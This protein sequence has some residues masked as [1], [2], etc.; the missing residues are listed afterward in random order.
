MDARPM[1]G[2]R[3][4]FWRRADRGLRGGVSKMGDDV[5]RIM[6]V[7]H[8]AFDPEYG[9]AWNRRQ[10]E[11]ALLLGN[12][13]YLLADAGGEEP[14]GEVPASEIAGFT[15]SRHGFGEEE[16]LLFAV[17]PRFRRRGV[18][19]RLLERFSLAAQAR[20]ARRLLL[21]M[22]RGNEA[23]S[24]YLAHGFQPIG[25]RPNY[26]RTLSGP[27]VDAITFARGDEN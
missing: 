16:L 6:A 21:E 2:C 8:T 10:V 25:L 5:D 24:L 15:L 22:R 26:Y 14:S 3:A 19:R 4:A 27:R 11:D 20:G 13:H 7:M 12:C 1:R 23:E 18:G 17:A 9:E